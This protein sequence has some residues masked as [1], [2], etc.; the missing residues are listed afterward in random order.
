MS[1]LVLRRFVWNFLVGG[2]SQL[3]SWPIFFIL[4]TNAKCYKNFHWIWITSCVCNIL[5]LNLRKK[6]RKK[7]KN[8][9]KKKEELTN[10]TLKHFTALICFKNKN[11]NSFWSIYQH[12]YQR[13]VWRGWNCDLELGSVW[14]HKLCKFWQDLWNKFIKITRV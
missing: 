3:R 11:F 6:W 4:Y 13:I 9:K 12:F 10:L 1:L 14:I 2:H 8:K 7:Q 5:V